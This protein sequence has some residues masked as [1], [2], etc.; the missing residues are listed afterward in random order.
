MQAL[1]LHPLMVHV[2]IALGV[3]LPLVAGG[4]LFAWW[5]KWL[6][7]RA[8]FAAVVLQA[9]LL[10]SGVLALRTGEAEEERVE[11]VVAERFIEAHEEAAEVFVAA[12]GLVLAVMLV[13]GVLRARST[14]LPT[15]AA[16]TLGTLLVLGLGYRT[17]RAG[18]SLVY[19][20]GAA[21]AYAQSGLSGTEGRAAARRDDDD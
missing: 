14:G 1:P 18:G 11:S 2:P 8:W 9:I 4:I 6:P 17:G 10:G 13:A 5:R 16:A 21:Q 12:S 15:A 7:P 19:E 3:L 20:Q